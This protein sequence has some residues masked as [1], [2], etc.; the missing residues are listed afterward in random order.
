MNRSKKEKR[1][2]DRKRRGVILQLRQ[3]ER[4]VGFELA[5]SAMRKHLESVREEDKRVKQIERLQEELEQLRR[6]RS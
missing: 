1:E 5:R 6:K 4:R 3:I 2:F